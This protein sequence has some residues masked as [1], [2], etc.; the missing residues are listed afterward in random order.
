[1]KKWQN[2][3][4]NLSAE[5]TLWLTAVFISAML[6]TIVSSTILRW[7]LS[8]YDGVVAKLAICILA[9]AAYGGVVVSVFYV[10]FP[11]MRM[12]LKRIFSEKK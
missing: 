10:M 6:G 3:L 12:A 2:W 11:E 7:G 4:E 9:T 1:M 5:Q 8:A